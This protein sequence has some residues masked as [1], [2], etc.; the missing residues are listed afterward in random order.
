MSMFICNHCGR[1]VD[2]DYSPC[3]EAPD[4]PLELLCED[5]QERLEMDEEGGEP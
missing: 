1:Y 4:N 2:S 5:C 3:Y